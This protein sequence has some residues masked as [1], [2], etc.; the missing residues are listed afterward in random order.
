METPSCPREQGQSCPHRALPWRD[1]GAEGP[2]AEGLV[3][4][5]PP[6]PAPGE[7]QDEAS[8]RARGVGGGQCPEPPPQGLLPDL[9]PQA[10]FLLRSCENPAEAAEGLAG[11]E[12][13][14]LS[15]KVQN[16]GDGD[17][18]WPGWWPR[19]VCREEDSGEPGQPDT[20]RG[21]LPA[22]SPPGQQGAG[23]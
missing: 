2:G 4:P 15:R 5:S 19:A 20:G 14:G 13:K 22:S 7:W 11:L 18:Q 3:H 8:C 16:I 9:L 23:S 17:P 21:S 6:A 12:R 10:S 1:E